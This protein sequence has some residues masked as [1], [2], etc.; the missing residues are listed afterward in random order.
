MAQK[1]IRIPV[2]V[3]TGKAR[4]GQD[5][6]A[7]KQ[8]AANF[9]GVGMTLPS[10]RYDPRDTHR[11]PG[12]TVVKQRRWHRFKE[13]FSVKR[14]FIA[15]FILLAL[16]GGFLGAKFLYNA[17]KI[18]GGSILSVL[19][20]T[21]LK[22][23]DV[24]RV[25]IL[26][27]GNSADDVGHDGGKL[28]DSIM[29]MSI[30]TRN[31]KAFLMSVPR[32]LY[33]P[34]EKNGHAK[35]NAAYVYG[36]E[37]SFKEDGL[38]EGGMGLLQKTVEENLGI[39]INYSALV[40]YNALRQAVD[41]VGGVD[42]TVK[43]DDPR[44]LYDPNID[45]KTKG[46]LVKLTNG[47]HELNG[48]QALNLARARGDSY[49]SYGY[50]Q[51]DF[52]RTENQRKLIVAL[53]TKAAT[54]GVIANPAKIGSLA[55]AIGGNVQTNFKLNEVRRLYDISKKIPANNITSVG[56]N[57]VD[58]K[59]KNL[60]V[61]YSAPGGQSALIPAAGIDDFSDIQAFLKRKTSSNPVVQEGARIVVL[62]GTTSDG[63]ASTKK[64]AL[65]SKNLM[66]VKT[67]DAQVNQA[68]TTVIDVSGGK[69]TAT[70]KLLGDMYKNSFTTVN[71]YSAIYDADFIIIVGSDQ[72]PKA[73][74]TNSQ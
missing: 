6:A 62:N 59:G 5:V 33:V 55:D 60:L 74:S 2:N 69:K 18:F 73:T 57:D 42:F 23:E 66:V 49:R 29:L 46:P 40:N 56:L 68:T 11:L 63:L 43:S 16:V 7:L 44:G 26:L 48:Q 27:A 41:A 39:D 30:D 37:D 51:S 10:Y 64:K 53:K 24:G 71:P 67:G 38:P 25:N 61:S 15:L 22:G 8:Q 35:I 9:P 4:P 52:T 50:A 32:D 3:A 58:G 36:E 72:I 21:K 45:Y 47:P 19:D 20:T 13:R 34:I 65:T 12:P 31:N 14:F 70:R 54:A 1:P 17:Q 28:T